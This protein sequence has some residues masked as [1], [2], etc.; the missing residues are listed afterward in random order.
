MFWFLNSRLLHMGITLSVLFSL[1]AIVSVE[2][3]HR[4]T[5]FVDMLPAGK[6]FW[7][8]PFKFAAAYGHVYKLHTDHIS[9]ETA[10]RRRKKVDDVQK[11]SRY[12]KAHGLEDQQGFGGWTAKSDAE[13]L[14]PALPNRDFSGQIGSPVEDIPHPDSA[15]TLPKAAPVAGEGDQSDY[16]ESTRR[17]RPVKRWLGIWE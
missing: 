16:V 4:S 6:E 13:S 9:A 15:E 8:H 5:P 2:N 7:S 3:F 11:R 10:E 1:A 12:R 14:G 17:K